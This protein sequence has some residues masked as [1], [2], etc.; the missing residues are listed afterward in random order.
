MNINKVQRFYYRTET[1]IE[2]DIVFTTKKEMYE[3][4]I[5]IKDYNFK[6]E[7]I[8]TDI[9][10]NTDLIIDILQKVSLYAKL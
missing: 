2:T 1:P 8:S 4:A 7:M 5:G 10:R 3:E 9:E 6:L